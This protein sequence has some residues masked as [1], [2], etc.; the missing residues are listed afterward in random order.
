[1]TPLTSTVK[2]LY[3][4]A[5]KSAGRLDISAIATVYDRKPASEVAT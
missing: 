2:E 3:E 5:A 4:R 1:M